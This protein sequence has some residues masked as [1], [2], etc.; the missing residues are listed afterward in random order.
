VENFHG[1]SKVKIE[2]FKENC[3]K[4]KR[5]ILNNKVEKKN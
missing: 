5:K 2:N 1:K 3:G 4:F